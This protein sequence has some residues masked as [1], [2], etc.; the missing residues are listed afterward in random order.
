[1]YLARDPVFLEFAKMTSELANLTLDL[2]DLQSRGE[3]CSA[4]RAEQQ[5]LSLE[6]MAAFQWVPAEYKEAYRMG[7]RCWEVNYLRR[8]R[9]RRDWQ[10]MGWWRRLLHKVRGK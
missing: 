8:E 4:K 6:F 2:E 1:M 9:E 7:L 3:D 10:R 5:R